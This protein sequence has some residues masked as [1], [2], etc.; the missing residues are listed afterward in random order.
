MSQNL[1]REARRSRRH[2]LPGSPAV[3]DLL[4][5][6]V[7]GRAIDMSAGGLKL[8][9]AEALPEDTL[10]QV[11]FDLDLGEASRVPIVAG[12]QVLDARLDEDGLLCTGARFIH[13]EGVHARRL[14]QW[15]RLQ[16]ESE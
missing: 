15:L 4:A 9:V 10:Y 13:L 6:R 8:L 14:V 11:R 16:A 1:G 12:I 3:Y 5:E 7:L 2:R